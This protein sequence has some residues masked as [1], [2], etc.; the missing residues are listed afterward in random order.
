MRPVS[1]VDWNDLT[2]LIE[3]EA[4]V[5]FGGRRIYA[6]LFHAQIDGA[7]PK[8][9]GRGLM[10]RPPSPEEVR[11]RLDR[12][13]Q[14]AAGIEG[15]S[16]AAGVQEDVSPGLAALLRGFARAARSGGNARACVRG[17]LAEIALVPEEL[18]ADRPLPP[19]D[20]S[21]VTSV[22][23]MLAA[24]SQVTFV[25]PPAVGL[26]NEP[27]DAGLLRGIAAIE[28]ASGVPEPSA[29]SAAL[30]ILGDRDAALEAITVIDPPLMPV[31]VLRRHLDA[32]IRELAS[33][34]DAAG[35]E[36]AA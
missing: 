25:G 3:G 26:P 17:A 7:G 29:R 9:L 30:S 4:I 20:G 24:A 31:G 23:P 1:R 36:Q 5:L 35:L 22:T 28:R 2:T 32:V 10:L 14:I 18:M 11:G 15:G 13:G 6:R 21:P 19:A 16:L 12:I 8:R 34:R 33:V 27:V